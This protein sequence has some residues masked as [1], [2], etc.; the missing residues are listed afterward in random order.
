MTLFRLILKSLIHFRKQHLA[1]FAGT[2]LSTAI[3]TGALITGDSVTYSLR[4]MVD[5]RLGKTAFAL[6]TG[7]RF[8]RAGLA[9]EMAKELETKTAAILKN[10]GSATNPAKGQRVG[11]IQILG[12]DG[13]FFNLS[14]LNLPEI[15]TGES[16]ISKNLAQKLQL[17]PGDDLVVRMEET[18]LIPVNAP[19]ASENTTTSSLR[20]KIIGIADAEELGRFSLQSNQVAPYN[21]FVSRDFLAG[22]LSLDGLA[23]L[24]LIG[25]RPGLTRQKVEEATMK[26]WKLGDAGLEISTLSNGQTELTSNRIFIGPEVADAVNRL[27]IKYQPV[28]TYLVNSIQHD[29]KSTPYSFVTATTP[30]IISEPLSGNEIIINQWLADDLDAKP[31]DTLDLSYYVIGAMRRLE[32]RNHQFIVKKTIPLKNSPSLR[33]L[34]PDF[35]GLADAGSCS[36]WETGVPIDLEAIRDKDEKYW[37]DYRG[38]PKAFIA[39]DTGEK[40]WGN[41]FGNYTSFRFTDAEISKAQLESR[42]RSLL[43]PRDFGLQFRPVRNEG[44]VAANNA[45]DFGELFLSLSFFV[46]AAGVLLTALLFSLQVAARDRESGT[47]AALGFSRGRIIRFRIL[48]ALFVIIPGAV[49]GTLAGILYNRGIMSGLNT[50]WMDVVRTNVLWIDVK[51]ATLAVGAFSGIVIAMAAI[52]IISRRKIRQPVKTLIS[53]VNP[54]TKKT[55]RKKSG[56]AKALLFAGLGISIIMVI[57]SIL[58]NVGRNSSL[59]LPAGALFLTGCL[60][61][62][63]LLL[64]RS[65]R[66]NH[67]GPLSIFTLALKNTG[68]N[69]S[70]SLSTIILL[71]LGTFTI[72]IT[73]ANRQTFYG[74]SDNRSSGTGGYALWAETTVPLVYDLNT[75]EGKTNY[76]LDDEPLLKNVKFVQFH[77]LR[78]D[79]ASCLNLNQVNRPQILGV[80]AKT[81]DRAKAFSF[82]KLLDG[83]DKDH[84]WKALEKVR[85]NGV[86]PVIADQTVITWGLMLKIGDTLT[87]LNEQGK[88]IKLLLVGGLKNSIFQG[89]ILIADSIFMQEFPSAGGSQIMLVDAPSGKSKEI[90]SLLENRLTD[91]GMET[92]PTAVRLATF[93]SVTNTYLSVFMILGG[94]GVLIGT[95]GLG[96]VI[97]RNLL[98]RRNE[99]AIY[100]ALGFMRKKI[101]AIFFIENLILLLAGMIS[102]TLAAIIGILPSL[103]SPAFTMNPLLIML[104]LLAVLING[105]LWI[106]FPVKSGLRKYSVKELQAE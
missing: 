8:V 50:V 77:N 38:T 28:I 90:S 55:G 6:Q 84:P 86:I 105:L 64:V 47:L 72:I 93:N 39:F 22:K 19:F 75:K 30:P 20:I 18:G 103:L 59:F 71:A 88:E 104:I 32:V 56:I 36:D 21:I 7:D 78:G 67:A 54:E 49:A 3:L 97:M 37:N 52:W 42:L 65:G 15:K 17:Q 46:I 83:V 45:V 87:Y 82:A 96:I 41:L 102:G 11:K 16:I 89:N 70:G 5:L 101:L 43:S 48:E 61:L 25:E 63:Y 79:D 10:Q 58:S 85:Q 91:F 62:I 14:G 27:N 66:K 51:P 74:T 2:L 76:G 29:N 1:L 12:I 69:L 95:I 33:K 23:N 9:G 106:Y 99:L 80:D 98:E 94:L 53:R 40:L 13:E 73:G 100:A 68:R 4:K 31:G 26:R 44:L 60:A 57:Y 24:I 35:P 81:F 92:T 34:M